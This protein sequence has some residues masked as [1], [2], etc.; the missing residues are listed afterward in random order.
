MAKALFFSS[1]NL[2]YIGNNAEVKAPSAVIL[3]NKLG[4]LKAIKKISDNR[5][6]E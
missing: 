1:I 5:C 3:L 2:T 4:N 6:F